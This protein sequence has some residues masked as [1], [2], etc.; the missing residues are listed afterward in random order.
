MSFFGAHGPD[1]AVASNLLVL[2][3]PAVVV[4]TR[5]LPKLC[6]AGR[7]IHSHRYLVLHIRIEEKH[8]DNALHLLAAKCIAVQGVEPL[9]TPPAT[10]PPA[11]DTLGS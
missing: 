11:L 8:M 6:L 3:G 7:P 5:F 10:R 9:S 4:H 1:Q 2:G